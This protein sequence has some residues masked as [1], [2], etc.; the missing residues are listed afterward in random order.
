ML[1]R[2]ADLILRIVQ[3]L[4]IPENIGKGSTAKIIRQELGL[5][6]ILLRN[7]LRGLATAGVIESQ[8]G[9]SGGVAI[10]EKTL[11]LTVLEVLNIMDNEASHA[12]LHAWRSDP[13][14]NNDPVQELMLKAQSA[15]REI[16]D[17]TTVAQLAAR[18]KN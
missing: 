15:V 6:A 14:R 16:F 2:E 11:G 18:Y 7:T 3:F 5:P 13:G 1:T 12:H 8:R 9:R 4:A 17:G 10:A